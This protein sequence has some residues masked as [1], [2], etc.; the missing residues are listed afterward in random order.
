MSRRARL[1]VFVLGAVGFAVLVALAVPGLP[2]IGADVHPARDAAVAGALA[3]ATANVVSSVNFDQRALDTLGEETILLASVVAVAAL[4]RPAGDERVVR[5]AT[6]PAVLPATRLAGWVLLPVTLL[7]GVDVVVHGH[8]TP[9][10]AFQGGVVLASAVHLLYLTGSFDILRRTGTDRWPPAVEPSGSGLFVVV[11]FV[12]LGAGA[13]FGAN[14]LPVGTLGGTLSS[15]TV[16]VL[17]LAVG[18]GV[19]AGLVHLLAQFLRQEIVVRRS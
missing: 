11:A 4:L 1:V 9:G 13:G 6:P 8:L 5:P 2:P 7:V 12:G 17:D 10:G 16:F 3:H 18:L 19:G 14:V 15:G